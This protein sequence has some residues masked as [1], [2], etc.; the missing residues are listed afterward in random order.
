M[1]SA[2]VQTMLVAVWSR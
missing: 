1:L 2:I